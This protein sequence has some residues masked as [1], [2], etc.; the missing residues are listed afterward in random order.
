M[1]W[2]RVFAYE[3]LTICERKH[4]LDPATVQHFSIAQTN[5][6]FLSTIDKCFSYINI[7]IY[8][9]YISMDKSNERGVEEEK[10]LTATETHA[11]IEN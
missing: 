6:V 8:Y 3:P 1:N 7:H 4:T 9:E 11:W 10:N 2:M 5:I